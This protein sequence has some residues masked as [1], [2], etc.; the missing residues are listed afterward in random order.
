MRDRNLCIGRVVTVIVFVDVV[1]YC[2]SGIDIVLVFLCYYIFINLW[3][4]NDPIVV[5]FL[6]SCL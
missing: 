1:V 6:S 3:T 5:N 2:T 4:M